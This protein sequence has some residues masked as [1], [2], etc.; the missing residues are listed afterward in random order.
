MQTA[1]GMPASTAS[2]TAARVDFAGAKMTGTAAPMASTASATEPNT[3]TWTSP[4]N[5]TLWPPLPGVTP[6]TMSVPDASM[7]WVCLRP[8]EP[9]MPWTTTL[10]SLVKKIAMRYPSL[11]RGGELGGLAGGAVHGVLERDEGVGG[12]GEDPPALGDVV[13][14]QPDDERLGGLVAQ[15]LQRV[16]DAV[17]HRVARGDAAEHVDEHALD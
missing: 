9:V 14:V 13:A 7:R 16:D 17:R 12:L 3:G 10:L 5:V 11:L 6:P 15:D 2:T 8:S 4:S 1:S